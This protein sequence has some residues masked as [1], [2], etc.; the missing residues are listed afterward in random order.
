MTLY[1][2]DRSV[3]TTG[4]ISS[5][6]LDKNKSAVFDHCAYF[7]QRRMHTKLPKVK[8]FTLLIKINGL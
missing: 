4:C 8:Y 6:P 7:E 3:E 1:R 2:I 5:A